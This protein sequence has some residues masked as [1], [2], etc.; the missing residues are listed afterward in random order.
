MTKR[1]TGVGQGPGTTYTP[2]RGKVLLEDFP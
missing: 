2:A 1:E